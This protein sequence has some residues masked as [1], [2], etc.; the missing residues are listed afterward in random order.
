MFLAVYFVHELRYERPC[1]KR[2][3]PTFP[4]ASTGTVLGVIV[5]WH[6]GSL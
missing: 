1:T 5:G 3:E 2:T 4:A 6:L